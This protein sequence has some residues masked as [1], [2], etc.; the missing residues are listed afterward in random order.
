M[1]KRC[2]YGMVMLVMLLSLVAYTNS[3]VYHD[4]TPEDTKFEEFGPRADRLIIKLYR[5]AYNE[6]K[7]LS[8]GSIDIADEPLTEE[9]IEEFTRPPLNET[10]NVVPYGA[11]FGLFMLDV[12]NANKTS[13]PVYP[14]PLSVCSFRQAVAHLVNRSWLDEIIGL[15]LYVPMWVPMSPSLGKYHLDIPNPYPYDPSA[16]AT[17]LDLDGFPVNSTTGWRFWDRNGNGMEELD[18]YLELKFVIRKDHIHR[19]AVGNRTA[20]ELNKVNVKVKR[21][22]ADGNQSY[23]IVMVKRD[24]HLYTVGWGLREPDPTYLYGYHSSTDNYNGVNDTEYDGWAERLMNATNQ[25]EAIIASRNA[26]QVFA[27][28]S[29]GLPLWAYSGYKAMSRR[30]TGGNGW[31]PVTPDD[32]ENNYRNITWQGTVNIAGLGIDN[33]FSFLNMHPLS[34]AYGNG[35][36]MTI[37]E[38]FVFEY[39]DLTGLNVLYDP[40]PYHW[41]TLDLIYDRLIRRDPTNTTEWMPWMVKNFTLGTYVHPTYGERTKIKFTLRPDI[42]WHDG[43]PLS[44]ADVYFTLVELDD[45]LEEH[46]YA[47]PWWYWYVWDILDFKI[48]DPYNFEVL[49]NVTSFWTLQDIGNVPI[50]PKHIWKPIIETGDPT[51]FAPDPNIIG[52]GPWKFEEYVVNDH[53]SLVAYKPSIAQ[54]SPISYEY[55]KLYPLY[56]DVHFKSPYE[57]SHKIPPEI[58]SI[59]LKITLENLI[60]EEAVFE[61]ITPVNLSDPVSSMWNETWPTIFWPYVLSYWVDDDT[62]GLLGTGDIVGLVWDNSTTTEWHCVESLVYE[63]P[64]PYIMTL[65]PLITITKY[66]TLDGVLVEPPATVNLKP[67]KSH[68]QQW[69][70]WPSPGKHIFKASIHIEEPNWNSWRLNCTWINYTFTFWVTKS[71]DVGGT[72]FVNPQLRA[73]DIKV[74]GKDIGIVAKAFDTKPGDE[75]W[76]GVADVNCDYRIEGKDIGIVAKW[77]GWRG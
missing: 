42:T 49:Y 36:N 58:K 44:T 5:N 35:E 32:G 39:P 67:E 50:M 52:S 10:I 6:W 76:E 9:W 68:K 74:E 54:P 37:R 64:G 26:Q 1:H 15:E 18:E 21:I 43:T 55:F 11:D 72:Y 40:Y 71:A 31:T 77:Y 56:V 29:F 3:W 16:A 47:P 4:G 73:P 34:Y 14:N 7:A 53:I 13:S 65:R 28:K 20:D 66:L 69:T 17:L 19:M 41:G 22:Y 70:Y 57:Y 8:N 30:Y 12:N 23:F 75:K 48:L 45:M 24:F 46:G 2:T 60:Q 51:G 27:N 38:G 61:S 62:S 33:F 63:P 59:E 25:E